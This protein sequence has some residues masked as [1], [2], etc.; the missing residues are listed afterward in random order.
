MFDAWAVREGMPEYA[1]NPLA[2]TRLSD[3]TPLNQSFNIGH[4]PGNWNSVPVRVYASID[5]GVQATYET[6]AL[7][8]YPFIRK[9]L[10]EKVVYTEAIPEFKTYVGSEAYGRELLE[11]WKTILMAA[12]VPALT[13][14]QRT[15]Y[16]TAIVA[17]NGARKKDGKIVTGDDALIDQFSRGNSLALGLALVQDRL[18][19]LTAQ[20][21][22]LTIATSQSDG[23]LRQ[24]LLDGLGQLLA[25]LRPTP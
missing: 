16:V 9:C 5:A 7:D 3:N 13:D 4:G 6:L 2:T 20:V 10:T 22:A 19:D 24:D 1:H 14:A 12:P 15:Q 8:Y 18:A 25:T 11:K 21:L 23:D 17:G